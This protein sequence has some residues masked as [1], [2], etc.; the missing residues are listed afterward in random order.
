VISPSVTFAIARRPKHEGNE[1]GARA[2]AIGKQ[3]ARRAE[4]AVVD[5]LPSNAWSAALRWTIGYVYRP[6]LPR[7]IP[8]N[9][10]PPNPELRNNRT[11]MDSASQWTG[12]YPWST[13]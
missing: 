12:C 1:P 7:T 2:V 8:I 4:A 6:A 10:I 9:Y 3:R 11:S 5:E 13:S